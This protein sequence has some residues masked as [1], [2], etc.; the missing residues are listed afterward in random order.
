MLKQVDDFFSLRQE[1]SPLPKTFVKTLWRGSAARGSCLCIG[2]FQPA[3]CL[4]LF[5][6]LPATPFSSFSQFLAAI[7]P[8]ILPINT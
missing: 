4:L 1:F 5:F 3:C 8:V 2:R 6:S 7:E